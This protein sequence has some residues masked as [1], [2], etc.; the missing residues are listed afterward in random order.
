MVSVGMSEFHCDQVVSF[1]INYISFQLV[2]DSDPLGDLVRKP[3]F[4]NLLKELWG[5]ML[6]HDFHNIWC[7]YCSSIWEAFKK[8]SHSKPMVSMAMRNIDCCQ[9]LAACNN[10][11]HQS[12]SLLD[13]HKGVD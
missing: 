4:P 9:V 13:S 7:C 5:G 11:I 6:A 12:I 8:S 1:E 10:P 3:H 2:S